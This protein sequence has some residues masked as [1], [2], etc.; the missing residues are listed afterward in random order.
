MGLRSIISQGWGNLAPVDAGTD[1]L[2]IGEIA[3]EMAGHVQER[4]ATLA[5]ERLVN[6]FS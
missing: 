1:C 4:G 3:H 2:S 6:R 5:A